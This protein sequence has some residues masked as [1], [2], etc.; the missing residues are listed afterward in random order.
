MIES[1]GYIN[2]NTNHNM[3]RQGIQMLPFLALDATRRPLTIFAS[4]H[5]SVGVNLPHPHEIH[6]Q[7][8]KAISMRW[9]LL[10][11]REIITHEFITE[12]PKVKHEIDSDDYANLFSHF[13]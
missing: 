2:Q 11:N 4:E 6:P 5:K 12:C 8:V 3:K 1:K 7:L 10:M 13:L 9:G